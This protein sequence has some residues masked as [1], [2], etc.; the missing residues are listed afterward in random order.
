MKRRSFLLGTAGLATASVTGLV[1]CSSSGSDAGSGD[2]GTTTLQMVES[3]TNPARTEVIKTMLADFEQANPTIKVQLVSPPTEQADNKIQQML[4][5]GSGVD[6]LEVRDTTVGPFSNNGWIY[7]MTPDME[8]WS[9]FAELTDQAQ[10]YSKDAS[11]KTYFIPYGFYGLTTFYRT[12]LIEE[13]G[14]DA[15]PKTWD[16]LLV[17][18]STIHDPGKNRFGYAFR[19]GKGGAGNLIAAI[20]SYCAPRIDQANA[21]KTTDGKSI[22]AAQEA[23]AAQETY[24]KLFKEAS[25]PSSVAWG[26]PEMVEGFNNGSTAFL[27]QDPEVIATI[28]ASKAITKDQWSTTP[29]LLG[30][31]GKTVQPIAAAG[32]GVA[33]K[34][35]NKE[36]AVKLVQFL[37]EGASTTFAKE[38]SLVPI[39]KEAAEDEFFKT[40]PWA[41][42]VTM[43]KDPDTW[44]PVVQP[45][46]VPWNTEWGNKA[47]AEL[48]QV[49]IG[50][51]DPAQMIAGWD[52][53]W[54]EKWANS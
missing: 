46:N 42:Y 8:A 40:G 20:S 21:F 12:D 16:E 50:K 32:W 27:L 2:G 45:R 53:Y 1:S 11:G 3:L 19:G 13:A 48:Q 22:F 52:A 33:E 30:P 29:M 18:A 39:R 37:S 43:T 24:F 4:Q 36:A 44:L 6:V 7:D 17:Q 23:T 10:Q 41:S 25:P 14:F 26:Y 34:S 31:G 49:L 54:T 47:D 5:A 15:P 35:P 9:G 28:N 51:L 38:N